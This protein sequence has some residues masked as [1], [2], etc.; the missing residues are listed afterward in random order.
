MI[1]DLKIIKKKYGE[2]MSH[3]CRKLFSTILEQDGV[4]SKLMLDNFN[5]SHDLYDDIVFNDLISEF[6]TFIYNKFY[7]IR[8]D[9]KDETKTPKELLNIAGYDLVECTKESEIQYFKKYYAKGEELCTFDGNRLNKCRVFFA[10]KKNVD[11]IKRENFKNPDRQDEYGTSVISIQFTKD[12]TNT[13]SIKNRYNHRVN[14]PDATFSN[15]LD[16]IIEGLTYSFEKYYG[17]KQ[18]YINNDFEIPNYVIANNG[19]YYKYNHE[20]NNIYYCPNN[21]VIDNFE[22]KKYEKE[23]YIILDYFI[24][25]LVNKKIM[26]YDKTDEDSFVETIT[27]IEK[28][29]II[30]IDKG[31]I[32]K[33]KTKDDNDIEIELD[34]LNRITKYTNNKITKINDWFLYKNKTLIELIR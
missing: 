14:N 28:I 31:K 13:L 21:I 7:K 8:R 34:K 24:L 23:K 3:L 15:N 19:K 27:N 25:D 17:I 29:E 18:A 6:K 5:T 22:V 30:N 4:L 10:I 16:N 32:I 2:N 11:E 1:D 12:K 26:L 33:I 20:I 9:I